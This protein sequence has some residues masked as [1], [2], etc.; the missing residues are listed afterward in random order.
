MQDLAYRRLLD[1]YYL[2]EKPIPNNNPAALIGMNDCLTDVEQVLNEY[3][4]QTNNGWVNNRAEQQIA[5]YQSKQKSASA[6]GK[7]SAEV[8][9]ANKDAPL[10][11][12]LNDRSTDVQLTNKHKPITNNHKTIKDNYVSPEGVLQNVWDDFLQLRKG[13][14]SA[15]TDTVMRGIQ[16]EAQKAGISLNDALEHCCI[17]GWQSFNA[18]WYANTK[19]KTTKQDGEPSWV[20]KNREWFESATGKTAEKDIFDMEPN[21]TRIAK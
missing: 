2:K 20:K 1:L 17:S 16:K 19:I 5:E 14:R 6:A 11:Q 8:R 13:K 9:K 18:E 12:T 4:V 21:L 15:V 10:E 3:F 7:K